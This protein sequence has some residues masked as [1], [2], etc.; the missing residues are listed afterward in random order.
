M[1]TKTL[2]ADTVADAYLQLLRDRGI[3]AQRG[4]PAPGE[5]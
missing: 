1:T 3:D 2:H 5:D 4:R